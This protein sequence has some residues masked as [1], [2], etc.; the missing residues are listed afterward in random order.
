LGG[1]Q[2]DQKPKIKRDPGKSPAKP[3]D[4]AKPDELARDAYI[5][6]HPSAAFNFELGGF[7]LLAIQP[8]SARFVAGFGKTSTSMAQNDRG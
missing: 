1:D 7:H 8:T 3:R 2:T 5:A 6:A 4:P